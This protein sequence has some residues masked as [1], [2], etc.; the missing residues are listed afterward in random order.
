MN[1]FISYVKQFLKDFSKLPKNVPSHHYRYFVLTNYIY[2]LALFAH[3]S[4]LLSFWL[5]AINSLALFNVG[6]VALFFVIINTNIRGYI[7][8]STAL[9]TFEIIAHAVFCVHTLG[10]NSG[11]HYYILGLIIAFFAA[12]V[13]NRIWKVALA[14]IV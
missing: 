11:F 12:P 2:L 13:K 1:S 3:A 6:S 8:L 14:A 10:W 7:V 5:I 9:A 4:L